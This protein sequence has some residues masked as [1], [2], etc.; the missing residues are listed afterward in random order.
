MFCECYQED[1]DDLCVCTIGR[2]KK[3]RDNLL[4]IL[5]QS[6][7]LNRVQWIGNACVLTFG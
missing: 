3:Y 2:E 6:H 1:K 4:E 5:M 7:K